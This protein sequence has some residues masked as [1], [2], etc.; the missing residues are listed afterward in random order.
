M[1]VLAKSIQLAYFDVTKVGST[2][3]KETLWEMEF[4]RPFR[5]KGID[6]LLHHIRWQLA[7]R[8]L[9]KPRN[10]H[11][12]EGFRC[13]VFGLDEVPEMFTKI[14]IV[15]DPASRIR[16]AWRDKIH[17]R[18]FR[19]RSEELDVENE[20]LP[21]NPTFGEFIDHFEEYRSIS[22]PAR[23]HTTPYVWHLGGDLTYFDRTF[24]LERFDD[25]E[26][27]LREQSCR[28][29]NLKHANVAPSEKRDDSLTSNQVDKLFEVTRQDYDLLSSIYDIKKAK[30]RFQL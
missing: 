1:V 23:V 28:K 13:T 4:G 7:R 30:R 25:F 21:L 2:S 16:S 6:R 11:E 12:V 20:G 3:V 15:R 17:E 9:A 8:K 24:T 10:I 27:F 18:Q 5:G 22:R 14:A 26:S 29:V 19:W